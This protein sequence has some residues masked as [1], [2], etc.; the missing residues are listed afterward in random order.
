[1][2]AEK[3]DGINTILIQHSL[4]PRMFSHTEIMTTWLLRV[5][6][7]LDGKEKKLLSGVFLCQPISIPIGSF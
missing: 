3:S 4:G 6:Q 7:N 2:L 5:N 1:M